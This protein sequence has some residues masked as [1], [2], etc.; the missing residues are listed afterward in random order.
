VALP[1]IGGQLADLK[2]ATCLPHGLM[3]GTLSVIL[4]EIAPDVVY[5][6]TAYEV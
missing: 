5:V 4:E 1:P 6:V 3:D 2:I